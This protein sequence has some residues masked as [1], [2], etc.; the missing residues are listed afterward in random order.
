MAVATRLVTHKLSA[1]QTRIE[2]PVALE[3]RG[4]YPGAFSCQA[5][6]LVAMAESK[7]LHVVGDRLIVSRCCVKIE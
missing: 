5:G 6:D 7:T 4:G 3:P 2:Q 1:Y